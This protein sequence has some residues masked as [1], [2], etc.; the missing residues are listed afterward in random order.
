MPLVDSIMRELNTVGFISNRARELV[1][2]YLTR[3]L[4]QDWRY[5]AHYFQ[6]KLLDYDMAVNYSNWHYVAG[7]GLESVPEYNILEESKSFDDSGVYIREWC[8]EL[9]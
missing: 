2:S 8:P 4:K 5:G 6:E 1:A 9:L 7:I 3:D